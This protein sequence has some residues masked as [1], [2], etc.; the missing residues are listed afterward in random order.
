M[1][2]LAMVVAASFVVA[3]CA[4]ASIIPELPSGP[5]PDPSLSGSFIYQYVATL[6]DLERLD[7]AAT[8][9]VTCPA[10][11]GAKPVQC[12]PAGTFF[13]IYDVGGLGGPQMT[14]MM[15]EVLPSGWGVSFNMTGL[16]PSTIVGVPDDSHTVNV[17]FKYTGPVVQGPA[18]ITGFDVISSDN[19]TTLG[20]YSSQATEKSTGLTHQEDS[21]ILV[22]SQATVPEPASM[23]LIGAG[24]I[25][26]AFAR[27]RLK[28]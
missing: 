10:L 23:A 7:P 9:G 21:F 2:H 13:T 27:K 26:L 19:A 14:A 22:P 1:R 12:N 16:T 25:G 24:L 4:S 15:T 20:F 5:V 28:R 6:S 17:T 18:T 8:G 11:S 3:F